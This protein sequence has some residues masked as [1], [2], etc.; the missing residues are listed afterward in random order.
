MYYFDIYR[1]FNIKM[2][3]GLHGIYSSHFWTE[4]T[5][6][7]FFFAKDT[8]IFSTKEELRVNL[9]Y[10]PTRKILSI[11]HIFIELRDALSI[12]SG[13]IPR[14]QHSFQFS[15]QVPYKPA[16]LKSIKLKNSQP[17]GHYIVPQY[18]IP[19]ILRCAL[20]VNLI[21]SK[22]HPCGIPSKLFSYLSSELL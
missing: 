16:P 14:E 17:Y 9:L 21:Y 15:D 1:I 7:Y 19:V 10:F 2:L 13:L 6:R 22:L 12:D 3:L 5:P 20:Q 11:L 4:R 18:S 8:G